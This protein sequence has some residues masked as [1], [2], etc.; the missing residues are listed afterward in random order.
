MAPKKNSYSRLIVSIALCAAALVASY[1][2]SI[3]ANHSEKFWVAIHPVA[4]GTQVK[5]SDLGLQSVSLGASSSRYL[6]HTANPIGSITLRNL[7]MGELLQ[8]TALTD[9]SQAMNHQQLAI[10]IRSVDLPSTVE[11]G[12]VV[13][14]FQLHDVKN[15][16]S[17]EPPNYIASGVFIASIDRKSS[18]FGGEVAIT[19]SVDRDVIGEILD[20]TTSG[21]LV[22]VKSHG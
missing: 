2:M 19:I 10:S 8:G 22:V 1:A 9:D 18:N 21:R 13:T 14:I 11:V 16:E 5:A 4:A 3:A 12:E 17:S 7:S 15:G 6:S 20:A